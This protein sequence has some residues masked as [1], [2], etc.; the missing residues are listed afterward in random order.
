MATKVVKWAPARYELGLSRTRRPAIASLHPSKRTMD[1]IGIVTDFLVG[2]LLS[3]TVYMVI[4]PRCIMPGNPVLASRPEAALVTGVA[5]AG[6]W[7]LLRGEN[8]TVLATLAGSVGLY[9][10]CKLFV[11]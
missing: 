2:G 3:S 8:Y 6:I 4:S 11:L 1:S 7:W 9:G 10:A 5:L